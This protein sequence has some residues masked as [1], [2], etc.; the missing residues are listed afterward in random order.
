MPKPIS[1]R[2]LIRRLRKFGFV[3]PFVGG[4]HQFMER[5]RR[6]ISIPNSHGKEI[7][8]ALLGEILHEIGV[9]SEEF[10]NL[11]YKKRKFISAI[12]SYGCRQ[13]M[14]VV[15]IANAQSKRSPI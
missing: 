8:S 15:K 14:T 5:D 6:R 11:K 10:E 3:G 4:R 1:R 7:G 2:E 12:E 13:N 9:T